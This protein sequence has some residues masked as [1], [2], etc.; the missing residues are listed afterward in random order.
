VS[1]QYVCITVLILGERQN[2]Y[3]MVYD[4]DAMPEAIRVWPSCT[5]VRSS[6]FL[7]SCRFGGI[8]VLLKCCYVDMCLGALLLLLLLVRRPGCSVIM[9][10][11]R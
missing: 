2:R 5:V 6:Y 4:G 7:F 10:F 11:R 1:K 8:L 9:C 3:R